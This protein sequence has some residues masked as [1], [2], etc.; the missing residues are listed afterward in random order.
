VTNFNQLAERYVASWN[1]EDPDVRHKL[2]EEL[3]AENGTYYNR[4][5]VVSGREMIETAVAREHEEYFQKGFSFRSQNDAY[6]H[7]KGLKFGWVMVS[8]ATGEVDTFGQ[9]FILLD[10]E[11]KISVDYMFGMKP[12]SV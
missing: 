6:G 8:T 4:L 7:H 11:G 5:F 9:E 12:P 3:W 2:V 10:D 1:E